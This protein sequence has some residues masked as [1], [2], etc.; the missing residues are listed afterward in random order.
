MIIPINHLRSMGP[1]LKESHVV[2]G[3]RPVWRMPTWLGWLVGLAASLVLWTAIL[4][5]A[6]EVR[7]HL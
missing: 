4:F 2:I 3:R 5:I 6:F 1:F 7:R